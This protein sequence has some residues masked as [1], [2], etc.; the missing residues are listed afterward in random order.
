MYCNINLNLEDFRGFKWKIDL[1]KKRLIY[2]HTRRK[3]L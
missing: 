1:S 2:I 3:R